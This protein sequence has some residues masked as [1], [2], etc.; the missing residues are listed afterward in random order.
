MT[1]ISLLVAFPTVV[2]LSLVVL[3]VVFVWTVEFEA[4]VTVLLLG[5]DAF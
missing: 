4:G 1:V 2:E 5:V 3:A